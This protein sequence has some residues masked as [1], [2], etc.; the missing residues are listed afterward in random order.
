ML[1]SDV[2]DAAQLRIRPLLMTPEVLD[3]TVN[4]TFTTDLL[5]PSRYLIKGQ[6]VMTGLVWRRTP[7]ESEA[8]VAAVARA[9]AVALLA[10]EGLFGF[11]PDDVVEALPERREVGQDQVDA[12][13]VLLGE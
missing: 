6:L 11:V 2:V 1:L 10:G 5:D 8:F 7:A 4:W 3:R 9:G 12:G 13:L